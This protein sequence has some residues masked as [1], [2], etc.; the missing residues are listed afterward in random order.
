MKINTQT[1]SQDNEFNKAARRMLRH[2]TPDTIT[3]LFAV[4]VKYS[5][6][7]DSGRGSKIVLTATDAHYSRVTLEYDSS[8]PQSY[9]QAWKWLDDHGFNPQHTADARDG[10]TLILCAQWFNL[11]DAKRDGGKALKA[12]SAREYTEAFKALERTINERAA[13]QA[14]AEKV[15]G[16]S[17]YETASYI[18]E[19]QGRE[20]ERRER[21]AAEAHAC[22]RHL[23]T[24]VKGVGD[25][26]A[27]RLIPA[28][29]HGDVCHADHCFRAR[30]GAAE[31]RE[32]AR[33]RRVV[34]G[35]LGT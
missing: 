26:E 28:R 18:M 31:I 32:P 20:E 12:R 29:R 17:N 27:E 10:G 3:R 35:L 21:A 6:P 34:G 11:A 8:Q 33:N 30:H 9:E 1:L 14:E 23:A 5:G 15:H 4:N 16:F 24:I 13:E 2:H 22:E 25:R 7:K 19:A